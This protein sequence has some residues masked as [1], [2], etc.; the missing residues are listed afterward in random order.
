MLPRLQPLELLVQEPL[1]VALRLHHPDRA[2]GCELDLL[3]VAS[4]QRPAQ[5]GLAFTAVV[6][7]GGVHVVHPG[8]DG[9]AE[10][11][12]WPA[13][14]RCAYVAVHHRQPHAPKPSA[15]TS[16]PGMRGTFGISFQVPFSRMLP[17]GA[18]PRPG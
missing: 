18:R 7:V 17:L 8:L 1:P 15:E 13:P 9:L 12:R 11:A 14:R 6:G 4:A 5:E 2:L 10:R 16:S 3:P